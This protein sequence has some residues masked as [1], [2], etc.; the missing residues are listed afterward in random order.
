MTFAGRIRHILHRDEREPSRPAVDIDAFIAERKPY[1]DRL[2]PGELDR[3]T[4]AAIAHLDPEETRRMMEET[5]E[6]ALRD[7]RSSAPSNH[8]Q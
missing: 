1:L 8:P 2:E 7:L 5:R 6:R 4:E 3:I